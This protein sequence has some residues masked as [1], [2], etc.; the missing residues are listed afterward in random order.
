[1]K[2]RILKGAVSELNKIILKF[3]LKYKWMRLTKKFLG[4]V[5]E[6]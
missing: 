5:G 3:T 6:G 1:M 2:T 4:K